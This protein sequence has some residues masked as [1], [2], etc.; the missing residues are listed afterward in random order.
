VADVVAEWARRR[1]E[2]FVLELTGPAGGTYAGGEPGP[3]AARISIDAV[4][5]CRT[6]AGRS[7]ATGLLATVVPF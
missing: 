4:E 6:L 1:G 5:F 2:A 7:R 3:D